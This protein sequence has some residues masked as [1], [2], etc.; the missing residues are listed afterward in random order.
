MSWS[1]SNFNP[2]CIVHWHFTIYLLM[3]LKIAIV[4]AWKICNLFFCFRYCK[5]STWQHILQHSLKRTSHPRT[6]MYDTFT[7]QD[8]GRFPVGLRATT[9]K[10]DRK[11]HWLDN[12]KWCH[13]VST[14]QWAL[15]ICF[16]MLITWTIRKCSKCL[17]QALALNA[18]TWWV[19]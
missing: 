18:T 11:S 8:Q 7:Y 14:N 1:W 12:T 9:A 4:S 6:A 2:E 19:Q 15:H 10:S 17:F 16:V 13:V 5:R 3:W